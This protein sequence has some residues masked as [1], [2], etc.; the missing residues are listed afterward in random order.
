MQTNSKHDVLLIQAPCVRWTFLVPAGIACLVGYLKSHGY[1]VEAI[2]EDIT[3]KKHLPRYRFLVG[4][5]RVLISVS[6]LFHKKKDNF[7]N[8][9]TYGFSTEQG[10]PLDSS[11]ICTPAGM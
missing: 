8:Q 3:Y 10:S 1:K 4:C 7:Q 5:H 11:A 6:K 2:D 9:K